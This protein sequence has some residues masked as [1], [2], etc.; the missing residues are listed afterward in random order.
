MPDETSTPLK[1]RLF[2]PH[3]DKQHIDEPPWDKR[4][5]T[6]HLCQFCQGEFDVSYPRVYGVLVSPKADVKVPAEDTQ[7]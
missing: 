6:T 4:V 7:P 1:A 5:H 2:C 3:C